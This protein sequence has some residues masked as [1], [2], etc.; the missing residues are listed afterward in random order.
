VNA[1]RVGL[2]TL[3]TSLCAFTTLLCSCVFF[4]K[5]TI[6]GACS[7]DLDSPIRNFCVVAPEVLWRGERPTRS[8]AKWLLEHRVGSVV[9]LQLDDQPAFEAVTLSE[10][11]AHVAVYFQEPAFNPLQMVSRS[12]IDYHVAR[13]LAVLKNAPKPVYFHCRAGIDRTGVLAAAY[14]VLIEGVG[15]EQAIAEMAR[16]HSPWI[17]L[18]SRYIRSLSEARKAQIMGQVEYW[19]TQLRPRARIECSR[20]KCTYVRIEAPP[21]RVPGFT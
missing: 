21:T 10:D 17:G 18:D 20:G 1:H 11:F 12:R 14:R 9:S 19:E 2:A 8:D 3:R 6:R 13:F 5:H 7:N 15:R 4:Y 16:F